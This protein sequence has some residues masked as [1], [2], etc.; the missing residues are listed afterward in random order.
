[1]R[2]R[3][4]ALV[5]ADLDA[6][7]ADIT[8]I[9]G[10]GEAYADPGVGKYGLRNQVWPIGDTFLEVV[11]PMREGTTAGRLISKRHGDGGYMAIFQTE[12][13]AAARARVVA[14]GV[15]IVDRIDRNGASFTHLHPK[16]VPGAIVS[17]DAMVPPERW[18]WGGP[19]WRRNV[20]DDVSTTIK[21]AE[22]RC[23][24]PDWVSGRWAAVLGHPREPFG[25]GWRIA[26]DGGELR[27]VATDDR[28]KGLVAFDLAVR[29]PEV[30][31]DRAKARGRLSPTGRLMLCGIEVRLTVD[32]LSPPL[33]T[34]ALR[35]ENNGNADPMRI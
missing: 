9:L 20:R 17:I 33:G 23:Q 30:V 14:Q 27:F 35:R 15:R 18:E 21:G 6:V 25:W 11:S 28:P 26:V 1:M 16:D 22:V 3:Q 7:S 32:D 4:V 2:L 24:D 12:D 29:R 13:I 10:L 8:A 34:S 5:A 31:L 19:D